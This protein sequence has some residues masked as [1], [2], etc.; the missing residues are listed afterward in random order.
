M[1]DASPQGPPS[2]DGRHFRAVTNSADGQVGEGT[3]F[4]YHEHGEVVWAEY[5]GGSIVRGYLIG[6][7]SG[8][9]LE[10]RYVHLDVHGQTAAGRCTSTIE[11]T[12]DGLVLHESWAWES[13]P[14]TGR[15]T[16]VETSDEALTPPGGGAA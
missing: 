10:F 7:R 16:L 4:A 12:V 8:D 1:T 2:L 14:G 5:D 15:S 11:M 13:R 3:T 9:S 6:S